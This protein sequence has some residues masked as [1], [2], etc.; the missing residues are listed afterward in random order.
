MNTSIR[1]FMRTGSYTVIWFYN[2]NAYK[3]ERNNM[4]Y[5]TVDELPV[6]NSVAIQLRKLIQILSHE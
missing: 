4:F 2:V 6:Q 5:K 1:D 3:T